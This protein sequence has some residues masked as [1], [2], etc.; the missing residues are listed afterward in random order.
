MRIRSYVFACVRACPPVKCTYI[1]LTGRLV[2]RYNARMKQ[3]I[4]TT[5]VQTVM[6][7]TKPFEIRDTRVTGFLLRVQP[8]GVKTYYAEYGRGKRKKIGRADILQP[9]VARTKARKIL[10]E[11]HDGIDPKAHDRKRVT[12]SLKVFIEEVYEPWTLAYLKHGKLACDRVRRNFAKQLRKPLAEISAQ[13]IERWRGKRIE[14]GRKKTT[15]N[16]DV[17]G[18][19]AILSRATEWKYL[20]ENPLSSVKTMKVDSLSKPRYLSNDELDA[21]MIALDERE[22]RIRAERTSANAWRA[23]RGRALLPD[24]ERVAFA[25]H[26]KPMVVVSLGTG[27]RRGE[28]FSLTW[29]FVDTI[30]NNITVDGNYAKSGKS[31]HIPMNSEVLQA[32]TNWKK[33]TSAIS[34]LVFR[35]TNGDKFDNVNSSWARVLRDAKIEK[36]RWHDMRHTF[37]SRLVMANVDLTTIRDFLGHADYEMTLRYAHLAPSHKAAAVERLVGGGGREG[38]DVIAGNVVPLER[39]KSSA[40]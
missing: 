3:L 12:T 35:S 34:G 22:A 1:A 30:Q 7:E 10:V 11:Y 8:S 28:L 21:L 13:E 36:F 39:S 16:R 38:H 29:E 24:L 25:D 5:L 17:N 27:M 6:A 19:K 32:L 15:V 40:G 18:L 4:S 26:L 9:D 37:A 33:Q 14:A 31:R 2:L 23:E 20:E